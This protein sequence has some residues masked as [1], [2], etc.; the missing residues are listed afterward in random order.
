MNQ[1]PQEEDEGE[2]YILEIIEKELETIGKRLK[3]QDRWKKA[4]GVL[5]R[6]SLDSMEGR[7]D[8]F[9]C[10]TIS[11]SKW[12]FGELAEYILILNERLYV[13]DDETISNAIK[14]DVSKLILFIALKFHHIYAMIST[15]WESQFTEFISV[16]TKDNMCSFDTLTM[17]HNDVTSILYDVIEEMWLDWKEFLKAEDF[18][19]LNERFKCFKLDLP[20]STP[21]HPLILAMYI[22]DAHRSGNKKFE[23]YYVSLNEYSERSLQSRNKSDVILENSKK[24]LD[25]NPK[26]KESV[27][28]AGK[29][30]N[31]PIFTGSKI[32]IC[33][34]VKK[35]YES[36]KG[37][38]AHFISG[39]EIRQNPFTALKVQVIDITKCPECDDTLV[40]F[41]KVD[42]EDDSRVIY[43]K[44]D[45]FELVYTSICTL[46]SK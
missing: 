29:N 28:S 12:S 1:Q 6:L 2:L 35:D 25:W 19:T 44:L 31:T 24:R 9:S 34:V 41:T 39:G 17:S 3:L 8:A 21:I 37:K 40:S 11:L 4:M 14:S 13:I 38:N 5:T 10:L 45:M 22:I 18:R 16:T 33:R 32:D 15:L 27:A 46:T 43:E 20:Y 7:V 42:D 23:A 30:K 36:I 26:V